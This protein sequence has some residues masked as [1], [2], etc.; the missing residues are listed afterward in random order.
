MLLSKTLRIPWSDLLIN[1]C[2]FQNQAHRRDAEIAEGDYFLIQS[3][4]ADC[5]RSFIPSGS[6]SGSFDG[7]VRC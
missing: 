7:Y 6:R 2:L 5:I 3:G 4:D 1:I